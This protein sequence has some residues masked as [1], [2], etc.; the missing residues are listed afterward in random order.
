MDRVPNAQINELC[1]VK[2]GL[3]ERIDECMLWW[4]T[5]VERMEKEGEFAGSRSVG[6]PRKRLLDTV[7]RGFDVRQARRMVQDRSE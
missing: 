6:R 7:K 1:R 3:D 5:H 4:F 2:K